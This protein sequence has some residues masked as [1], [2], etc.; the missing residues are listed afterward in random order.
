MR[1]PLKL[2]SPVVPC[3]SAGLVVGPRDP[4]RSNPERRV[5][6]QVSVNLLVIDSK[7]WQLPLQPPASASGSRRIVS[8][9]NEDAALGIGI[10]KIGILCLALLLASRAVTGID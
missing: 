6:G 5:P 4:P 7:L 9:C 3:S 1:L 10:M 2:R 8:Q